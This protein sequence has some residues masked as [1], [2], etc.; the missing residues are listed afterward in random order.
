MDLIQY[1]EYNIAYN[2]Q[3]QLFWATRPQGTEEI[4]VKLIIFYLMN[5]S[6]FVL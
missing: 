5:G 2:I 1:W 4:I 3:I 6:N